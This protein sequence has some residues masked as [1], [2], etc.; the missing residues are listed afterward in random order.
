MQDKSI[1]FIDVVFLYFKNLRLLIKDELTSSFST[2]PAHRSTPTDNQTLSTIKRKKIS[3]GKF[4]SLHS[5]FSKRRNVIH[6]G[7]LLTEK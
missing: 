3:S 7:E 1:K 5:M 4:Y 6:P 2:D